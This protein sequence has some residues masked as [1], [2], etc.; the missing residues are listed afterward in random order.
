MFWDRKGILSIDWLPEKTTINSDYYI[1]E[2]EEIR[3]VIKRERH[4]K[5]IKGILLQH[6]D[7]RPNVS[8]QTR[9]AI[10]RLG[11]EC[12]PHAPYSPNLAPSDYWLFGEM[13]RPLR[14][15]NSDFKQLERK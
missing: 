11:S 6:D 3:E 15:R 14:G 4:G 7:A 13:K 9:D 10:H 8:Y 1:S 2:H 12:L 5:L